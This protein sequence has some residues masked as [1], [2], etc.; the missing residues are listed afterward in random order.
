MQERRRGYKTC[1]ASAAVEYKVNTGKNGSMAGVTRAKGLGA[2]RTFEVDHSRCGRALLLWTEWS[3][4]RERCVD[5]C[6][7]LTTSYLL[8]P[9]AP[10]SVHVG[11]LYY[12]IT[13]PA[14]AFHNPGPELFN[15]T[16][17]KHLG[18]PKSMASGPATR[19]MC[20]TVPAKERLWRWLR[21]SQ[22]ARKAQHR[23]V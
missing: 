8:L 17:S 20:R 21:T 14:W 12:A 22:V 19:R 5:H 3:F 10:S 11:L 1:L 16:S 18:A 2:V 6:G 15:G 7:S 23:W 13:S 4:P 9:Q